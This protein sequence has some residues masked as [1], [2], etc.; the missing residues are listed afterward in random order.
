VSEVHEWYEIEHDFGYGEWLKYESRP[1]E[2]EARNRL[3]EI[4]EQEHGHPSNPWYANPDNYRIIRKT[5]EVL[6]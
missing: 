4:L 5:R 6:Q 2:T 3:K 1:T